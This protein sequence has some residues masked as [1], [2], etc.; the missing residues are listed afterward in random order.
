MPNAFEAFAKFC[1]LHI[2]A[3]R[4]IAAATRGEVEAGEMQGE[5]WLLIQDIESREGRVLDLNAADDQQSLLRRLYNKLVKFPDRTIRFASKLDAPARGGE[6]QTVGDHLEPFL[7]APTSFDPAARIEH[8]E[9][10]EEEQASLRRSYSQATAYV[11]LLQRFRFDKTVLAQHLQL[12][13]AT[14]DGRI[15][16]AAASVKVQPSVFDGVE[17]IAD[18]FQP[19]IARPVARV[20]AQ[21]LPPAQSFWRFF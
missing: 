4:R 6:G 2:A 1:S 3:F 10:L 13:V 7:A 15:R 18:D 21:G 11:L 12:A 5:A 9:A 8:A 14:L 17:V 19:T 20:A 16:S